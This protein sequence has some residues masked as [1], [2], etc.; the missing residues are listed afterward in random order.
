M[1]S[2]RILASLFAV[3][4]L[5][6]LMVTAVSAAATVDEKQ[7]KVTDLEVNG[8]DVL[9]GGTPVAEFSGATIPVRIQFLADN[10][11][12]TESRDVRVKAWISGSRANSA[13]TERFDVLEDRTYS[14]VLAVPIPSDFDDDETEEE[15][16][17]NVLIE[18]KNDGTLASVEVDLTV[19]KESYNLNIL[20]VDMDTEAS[21]GDALSI[22]VVLKNVGRQF[23]DDAFVVA[24]IPG[25]GIEDKAY[26]GDLS[27]VDQHDPDKENTNERR[28]VLRIPSNV[29]A[30]V[31]AVEVQAYNKDSISTV[32]RQLSVKAA[33]SDTIVVAPVH[34]K[35]FATGTTQEYS[36][37]IVNPSN[38]VQ[39]YELVVEASGLTVSVDEPVVAVPAGTSKT[40][41][42]GVSSDTEGTKNFAVNIHS[43]AQLVKSESFTANVEGGRSAFSGD[44]TV[45][46]T[47]VLAIIFVVLLVVLIVLLTK[48]PEKSEEFGESY[49]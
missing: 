28:L 16:V 8:V 18:S 23:A 6:L 20:D 38:K 1:T 4:A 35:T 30:G 10:L 24:R 29:P 9:V 47:V 40:V 17:L 37:T 25:L 46:L 5:A 32:T 42:V 13:V 34:S 33:G 26:F 44:A 45:L 2:K 7:V 31:Y 22:D 43:G 41:K 27:A 39:V 21:A 12:G 3:I 48:K 11:A 15:L 36:L 14:R 49:Y 19:Q